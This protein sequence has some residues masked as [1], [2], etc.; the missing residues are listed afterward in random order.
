[1]TKN[2]VFFA[3]GTGNDRAEGGEDERRSP[4]RLC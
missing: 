3:D 4:K 2:I 1:M